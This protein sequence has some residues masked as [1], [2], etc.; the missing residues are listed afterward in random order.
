MSILMTQFCGPFFDFP[1]LSPLHS[2]ITVQIQPL[3]SETDIVPQSHCRIYALTAEDRSRSSKLN[4]RT[5]RD[6]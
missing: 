4:M 6:T 3:Q 1:H 2:I 5:V